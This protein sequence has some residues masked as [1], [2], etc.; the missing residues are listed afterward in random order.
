[1]TV[2]AS[3]SAATILHTKWPM[4][5]LTFEG[6]KSPHAPQGSLDVRLLDARVFD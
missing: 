6:S 1:M 5:D 2:K 4:C 3:A